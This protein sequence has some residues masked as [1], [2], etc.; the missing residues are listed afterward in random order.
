MGGCAWLEGQDVGVF[1]RQ[2][3]GVCEGGAIGGDLQVADRGC[4]G[5]PES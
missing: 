2:C 1:W 3:A 5:I 4:A